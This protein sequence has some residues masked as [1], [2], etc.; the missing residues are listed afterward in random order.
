MASGQDLLQPP[1]GIF[2]VYVHPDD[3][4]SG[5]SVSPKVS[6]ADKPAD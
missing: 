2:V 3:H 1:E 6:V 5:L 4:M